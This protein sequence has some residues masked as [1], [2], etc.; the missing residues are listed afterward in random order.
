MGILGI[1]AVI[2]LTGRSITIAI[3]NPGRGAALMCVNIITLQRVPYTRHCVTLHIFITT[4]RVFSSPM[5][6]LISISASA[7]DLA[8]I[9]LGLGEGSMCGVNTPRA[10]VE[11]RILRG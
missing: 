11:E 7:S 8:E 6:A 3:I 4:G 1:M 5:E 9:S 10:R 2:N